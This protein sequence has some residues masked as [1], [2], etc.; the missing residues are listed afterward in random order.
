MGSGITNIGGPTAGDNLFP[1]ANPVRKVCAKERQDTDL[2]RL[3]RHRF[4]HKHRE[5][6]NMQAKKKQTLTQNSRTDAASGM[7]Y[8]FS[9][10]RRLILMGMIGQPRS[11]VKPSEAPNA[12]FVLTSPQA[13][14]LL[15]AT[16]PEVYLPRLIEST[17]LAPGFVA[18]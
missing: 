8:I 10:T 6:G 2:K 15:R 9:Q 4:S 18:S 14:L 3:Q 11:L 17:G 1:A 12:N 13:R 7:T 16:L 5:R